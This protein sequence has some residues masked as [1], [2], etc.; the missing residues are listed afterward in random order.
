MPHRLLYGWNAIVELMELK[1]TTMAFQ[2]N[3]NIWG[4]T[5]AY[6]EPSTKQ[7]NIQLNVRVKLVA[8]AKTTTY[9]TLGPYGM[10]TATARCY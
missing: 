10:V 9:T 3:S 6:D 8:F 5:P 7:P 4:T 1:S 2:P